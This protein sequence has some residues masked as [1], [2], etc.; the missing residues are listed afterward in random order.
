MLGTLEEL[1]SRTAGLN[2]FNTGYDQE[3][4]P[5]AKTVLA[6]A[7]PPL[8]SSTPTASAHNE[9]IPALANLALSNSALAL[10]LFPS[11]SSNLLA[12]IQ[13]VI[14]LGHALIPAANEARAAGKFF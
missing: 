4:L 9:S 5:L 6:C 12:K 13:S 10:M 11:A 3:T 7:A 8:R 1:D 2:G 14:S